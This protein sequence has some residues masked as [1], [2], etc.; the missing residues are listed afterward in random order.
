MKIEQVWTLR[1]S[2][3]QPYYAI[4]K[5]SLNHI[6]SIDCRPD[7]Q[8]IQSLICFYNLFDVFSMQG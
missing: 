4:F 1:F 3:F 2:M 5:H 6:E 7:M 8:P